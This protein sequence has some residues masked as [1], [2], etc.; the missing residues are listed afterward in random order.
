MTTAKQEILQR[1]AA[2]ESALKPEAPTPW[3]IAA[4]EHAARVN[5]LRARWETSKANAS[6]THAA[7]RQAYRALLQHEETLLTVDLGD[8]P[9][10]S[11]E[12]RRLSGIYKTYTDRHDR[13]KELAD[14]AKGVYMTEAANDPAGIVRATRI[15]T[16]RD[17][18]ASN[19]TEGAKRSA[20]AELRKIADGEMLKVV[21]TSPPGFDRRKYTAGGMLIRPE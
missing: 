8:I 10:W 7:A 5:D 6:A 21:E 18:L 2:A 17:I 1:I 16:L 3:A 19:A 9:A 12:A 14:H 13:E 11:D 20:A 15:K 4:D